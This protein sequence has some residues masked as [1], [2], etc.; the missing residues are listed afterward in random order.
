MLEL[1]PIVRP[2]WIDALVECIKEAIQ[3]LWLMGNLGF[4]WWE[5]G[6][7]HS[8]S[9]DWFIVVFPAPYVTQHGKMDGERCS[10]GYQVDILAVL[11]AFATVKEAHWHAP[12]QSIGNV[13]GP[14]LRIQGVFAGKPVCL[15]VYQFPPDDEPESFKIDTDTMEIVQT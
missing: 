3:P 6:N 14:A 7:T 1:H 9:A 13:D 12:A 11:N 2:A 5:P 4:R 15:H 8:R 10:T